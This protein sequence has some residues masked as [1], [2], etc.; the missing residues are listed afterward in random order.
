MK[1]SFDIPPVIEEALQVHIQRSVRP[2]NVEGQTV[3]V[4]IFPTIEAFFE[5]VLGQ[6]FDGL[7]RQYRPAPVAQKLNQIETLEAEVRDSSKVRVNRT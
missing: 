6:V 4:P 1:I 2:A 7:L 5:S 3:L